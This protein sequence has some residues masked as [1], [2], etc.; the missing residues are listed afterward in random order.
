MINPDMY[1]AYI[2]AQHLD[3]WGGCSMGYCHGDITP[4]QGLK[5]YLDDSTLFLRDNLKDI[6]G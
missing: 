1:I 3:L 4:Q 2:Y 6:L 5:I